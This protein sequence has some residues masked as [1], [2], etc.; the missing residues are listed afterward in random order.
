M[1]VIYADDICIYNDA[2]S[3][4]DMKLISPKLVLED[5]AAGTLTMTVPASNRGYS[6]IKRMATDIFVLKD[7]EEIWR[8]RVLSEAEDFYKN[9]VLSCE[10]EFAFFNDSTQPPN[11]YYSSSI[12]EYVSSLLA[13]HNSKVADNRQF[14]V[15]MVTVIDD[16]L[17]TR[18]TNYEKTIEIFNSLIE[19]Y[20]GHFRVRKENGVRY[21]DYLADYPDTCTQTIQFGTNLIEH[22]KGWDMS[23]FATVI[24]PLGNR[25]DNSDIAE[26]DAYLTI[27][28]VNNGSL[29][30]QSDEAVATYGWI[31]KTV[32]WDD[33]SDASVLLE[34]AKTYLSDL[35]FDNMELEISAVDLH[36]LNSSIEAVKLLDE[37]RVISRPHGLDRVF[38]VTK[39][40]I[41]LDSPESTQFKMGDTVKTSLTSVN[42][43]TSSA[44]LHK[45]EK[46][47]KAHQILQDAK[48]NATAIM[49]AATTG[50]VTI[51]QDEYGA[52]AI[53]I[54]NVRDYTKADKLWKWNMNGLGYSKDYGK[55]F[56]LAITM[57]GSIVADYITSGVMSANVIRAGVLQDYN[58]NF[59]LDFDTGKLVM[60]KG[61]IDIGNGIFS[62]DESG[63]MTMTK[64]SINI[65]NGKFKVE[66]SGKTYIGSD[67]TFAGNLA[68]AGGTF[69]GTLWAGTV[70]AA[71]YKDQYGNDMM[72]GG[73]FTADY[74]ELKGIEITDGTKTTF[75]VNSSG[76]VNIN[77]VVTMAN[78]SSINWAN[79]SESNTASSEAYSKASDAYVTATAAET[80]ASDAYEARCN[81]ENVFNVLT[82]N[83]T[84]YGFYSYSNKLYIN[85]NYIQSGTLSA[86]V[87]ELTSDDGG[88]CRAQG[89]DGSNVTTYG[90]MMYGSNGKDKTPYFIVTNGGIRMQGAIGSFLLV[91]A[92]QIAMSTEANI[93]SDLRLKNTINY[94]L[95]A[96]ENFFY[97]LKAVTF[98]YNNGTSGR[99][100]FGFIAQDVE[101]AIEKSGLS[102]AD[103][104]AFIKDPVLEVQDDGIDDYRYSIRYGELIALNTYMIQKLYQKIDELIEGKGV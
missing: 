48:D 34:K 62:V 98:K 60:K 93:T 21:L 36:Y 55:T 11:R 69:S 66:T 78:G 70:Y 28:S 29:Y 102:S 89:L 75:K 43:K 14:T 27:E 46:L 57:D 71:S 23:E 94:D 41:P 30:L 63:N 90:A 1:Y 32:S 16:A 26:L 17:P 8:G 82:S 84:K 3:L 19:E 76:Q 87:L 80:K 92:S 101:D 33:V 85:A 13:V 68:S 74:L 22:T 99:T 7:G 73:K 31:E 12:R 97:N 49:T 83:G 35:Q 56:G 18:Y 10:G 50:F 6:L 59:S 77:G 72:S 2:F 38:P 95:R 103:V 44:I 5:N 67:A 9:R 58:E 81:D 91:N 61:S 51:T 20:G 37:I 4:E 52:E 24:V 86:D 15:G 42:N 104:A 65:G 64:G 54:S 25:L 47:P 96:Y 88:F 53:Y 40:E 79:V 39:L 100:H 45:I